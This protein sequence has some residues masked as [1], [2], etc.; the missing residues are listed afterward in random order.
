MKYHI[1]LLEVITDLADRL[2]H[3]LP[4]ILIGEND[5]TKKMNN[6]SGTTT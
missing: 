1:Q 6:L 3:F 2:S 4:N 5:W